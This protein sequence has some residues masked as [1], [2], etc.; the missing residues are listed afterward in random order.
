MYNLDPI[1]EERVRTVLSIAGAGALKQPELL[2]ILRG[3]LEYYTEELR[4]DHGRVVQTIGDVVP[5]PHLDLEEALRIMKVAG[6]AYFDR[7]LQGW[8]L[9]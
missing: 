3:P 5:R 7:R 1:T 4:D 9:R 6:S 2:D 8:R